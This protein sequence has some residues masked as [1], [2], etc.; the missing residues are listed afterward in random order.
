M[1]LDGK[2]VLVTGSTSAEA[3]SAG[4]GMTFSLSAGRFLRRHARREKRTEGQA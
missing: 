4:N 2:V 3:T 1:R